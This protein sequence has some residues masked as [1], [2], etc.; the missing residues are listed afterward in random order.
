MTESEYTRQAMMSDL[1][2]TVVLM[3]AIGILLMLL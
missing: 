3:V 1:V 2:V